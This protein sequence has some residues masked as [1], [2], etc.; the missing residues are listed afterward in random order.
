M[1]GVEYLELG[2]S[3]LR[4]GDLACAGESFDNAVS[5][6]LRHDDPVGV[7]LGYAGSGLRRFAD[8]RATGRD[9]ALGLGWEELAHALELGEAHGALDRVAAW[10]G[11]LA[12]IALPPLEGSPVACWYR[13]SLVASVA[14]L[15]PDP[16]YPA[17][18]R[19]LPAARY[20][21]GP[22]A[23]RRRYT[24]RWLEGHDPRIHVLAASTR[25][26]AQVMISHFGGTMEARLDDPV[27]LFLCALLMGASDLGW[28][29]FCRAGA[30]VGAQWLPPH[31]SI[32]ARLFGSAPAPS[33][34]AA[35]VVLSHLLRQFGL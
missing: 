10:G 14:S 27:A 18:P 2:E 5:W 33:A 30:P 21:H 15:A 25:E 23:W 3:D 20:G 13:G 29:D 26:T 34:A 12:P 11:A 1:S 32:H 7:A 22:V 35:E 24:V 16:A 31:E 6:Y 4:D 9:S 17:L 19:P 8:W 28:G